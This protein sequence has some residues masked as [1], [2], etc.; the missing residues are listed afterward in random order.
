MFEKYVFKDQYIGLNELINWVDYVSSNHK[1]LHKKEDTLWKSDEGRV[2]YVSLNGLTNMLSERYKKMVG[3]NIF[4]VVEFSSSY[5]KYCLKLNA[6][7]DKIS[8]DFV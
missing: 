2:N 4:V 3:K 5:C 1:I 6:I 7:I 8:K